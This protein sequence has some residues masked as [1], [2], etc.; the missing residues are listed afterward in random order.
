[1]IT[2]NF[3]KTKE[4]KLGQFF[5]R[6]ANSTLINMTKTNIKLLTVIKKSNMYTAFRLLI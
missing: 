3:Y 5:S 4:M 1:M 6:I 2:F